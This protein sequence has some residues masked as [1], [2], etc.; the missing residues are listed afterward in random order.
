MH[1]RRSYFAQFIWADKSVFFLAKD[2]VPKKY[3]NH[4]HLNIYPHPNQ[5]GGTD[6]GPLGALINNQN[7]PPKEETLADIGSNTRSL[8]SGLRGSTKKH[9]EQKYIIYLYDLTYDYVL[10]N[11][12]QYNTM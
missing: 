2:P 8:Y 3:F 10:R 7:T 6:G 12:I 9:L 4:F 11:T 5:G 1:G